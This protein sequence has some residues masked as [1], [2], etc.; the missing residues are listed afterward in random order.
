MDRLEPE[1]P[2]DIAAVAAE[3][4][5][6]KDAMQ[7]TDKTIA[8]Y[9]AQLNITPPLADMDTTTIKK[10][11]PKLRFKGDDGSAY[12]DWE[13]RRLGEIATIKKGE[14]LNKSELAESGLYPALNGGINPS[15]YIDKWNTLGETI[16]ISEGGNSCGYVNYLKCNFWC[17]GHCYSLV[18]VKKG[19]S[20]QYLFQALKAN[21][22]LIMK[23]RVGSGLPN[24]QKKDIYSFKLHFPS[25]EEQQKIASFLSAIDEKIQQL[26][27]EKK[28]LKSYKKGVMQ[29]LFSQQIRFKKKDGSAYPDWEERQLREVL[30]EH[31]IKS[32]GIEDVH[33]VSVD[34]G[35]VNQIEHLGR[36][37]SAENTDN[38]NLVRPNDI[39]YT[40]SPTG[41]FTYGI[42]KQAKTNKNVIVSPLYAVFTPET[43][44]MGYILDSYFESRI[45]A[46]N[47][48]HSIVQKGAKNTIN[49]TSST[50]TSKSLKL[51]IDKSEEQQKVAS[52]LRAIDEKIQQLSKEKKR[53]ESFKKALL[54]QLFV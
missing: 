25:F 33:S 15:G 3:L 14:Q 26:S 7:Q 50:F 28:R 8:D 51:P 31:R 45:N 30:F 43:P 42:I 36:S 34:R 5:E 38:Y 23:L 2:V 16:T 9:C 53:L 39:V 46:Y 11:M 35:L 22:N 20:N 1:A 10:L 21:E 4:K 47:Y 32:T 41:D 29:Q 24:I 40:K 19:I 52:F 44:D 12:P 17:G 48:L 6:L 27:K 37:F 18:N 49:I 54:Q 13:E